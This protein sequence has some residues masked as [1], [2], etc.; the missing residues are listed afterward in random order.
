MD[1]AINFGGVAYPAEFQAV[2]KEKGVFV[3][4]DFHGFAVWKMV[5]ECMGMG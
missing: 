5:Y 3:Y 1:N 4:V 2:F